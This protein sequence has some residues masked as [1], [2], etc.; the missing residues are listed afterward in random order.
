MR[1]NKP[2]LVFL[3]I[4]ALFPLVGCGGGGGVTMNRAARLND[5]NS[6]S[7]RAQFA[8]KPA[9]SFPAS[10]AV[11]RVEDRGEYHHA[12]SKGGIRAVTVRNVESEAQIKEMASWPLVSNV[13]PINHLLVSRD[14]DDEEGLRAAAGAM[15]ADLLVIYTLGTSA[16]VDDFDIGPLGFATLGFAPNQFVKANTTAAAIIIDVRTGYV[17]GSAESTASDTKIANHWSQDDAVDDAT[18]ATERDAIQGL[19]PHLKN[20]WTGIVEQYATAAQP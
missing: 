16:R 19:I 17:Y 13:S 20:T 8:A 11:V 18:N 12:N 9:A 14:T 1:P 7:V 4:A 2:L 3:S 15:H 10:I 5:I 6:A